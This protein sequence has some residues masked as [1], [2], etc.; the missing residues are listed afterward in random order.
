MIQS[1][2]RAAQVL[3]GWLV[4]DLDGTLIT[5]HSDKEGAAPTFKMGYGGGS[6]PG[7]PRV[8]GMQPGFNFGAVP[9]MTIT[10]A[11]APYLEGPLPTEACDQVLPNR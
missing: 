2:E 5:A 6:L 10:P 7:E 4:I 11:L 1:V 3:A 8:Q 9:V